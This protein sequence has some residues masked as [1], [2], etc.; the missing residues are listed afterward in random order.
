MT[1][2]VRDAGAA[3]ASVVLGSAPL[4]SV[5]IALLFLGEPVQVALIAGRC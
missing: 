4:V 2:A 5:T 3:R 1:Y